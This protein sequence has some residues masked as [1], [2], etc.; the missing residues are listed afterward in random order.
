MG[1]IAIPSLN[2]YLLDRDISGVGFTRRESLHT[3]GGVDW[4]ISGS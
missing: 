4:N 3:S 2:E 1:G